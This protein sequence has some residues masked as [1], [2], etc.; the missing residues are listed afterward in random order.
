VILRSDEAND[1]FVIASLNAF[2]VQAW[3]SLFKYLHLVSLISRVYK[4]EIATPPLREARN[5]KKGDCHA[6]L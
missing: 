5:V 6:R 3:Q 1:A 4:I 2:G